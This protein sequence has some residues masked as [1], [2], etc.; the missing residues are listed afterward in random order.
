[1]NTK[2]GRTGSGPALLFTWKS[3]NQATLVPITIWATL[4]EQVGEA[5]LV[6]A[7]LRRKRYEIARR[8]GDQH[9]L[10]ELYAAKMALEWEMCYRCFFWPYVAKKKHPANQ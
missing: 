8:A 5:D 3:M 7:N 2:T 6:P 9:A 1:M 10:G 4:Y